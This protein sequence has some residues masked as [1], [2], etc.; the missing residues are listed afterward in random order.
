MISTVEENDLT[1][2]YRISPHLELGSRHDFESS[3]EDL[4]SEGPR[5]LQEDSEITLRS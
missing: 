4:V 3:D 5:T 1:A 2:W